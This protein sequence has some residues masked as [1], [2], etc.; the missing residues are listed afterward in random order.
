MATRLCS[1]VRIDG[2]DAL[3]DALEA[4]LARALGGR[5]HAYSVRIDSVGRVGEVL[6]SISGQSGRLPLLFGHEELDPG[7]VCAVVQ[8]AVT[9]YG[10]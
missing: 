8:G 6:V 4:P 2:A 1:C 3:V 10:L 9:K 5:G 7:Y